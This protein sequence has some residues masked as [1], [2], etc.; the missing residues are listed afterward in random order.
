M[1]GHRNL[2]SEG[3]VFDIIYGVV[4]SLNL[5]SDLIM[6]NALKK[7]V[8]TKDKLRLFLIWN[9]GTTCVC[10]VTDIFLSD[11]NSKHMALKKE[12]FKDIDEESARNTLFYASV[13]FST[14][15][16]I[17]KGGVLYA[18][19]QM[20][21]NYEHLVADDA[22]QAPGVRGPLFAAAPPVA[23]RFEPGNQQGIAV[24]T[25]APAVP[26]TPPLPAPYSAAPGWAPMA[27]AYREAPQVPGQPYYVAFQQPCF[28]VQQPQPEM[29]P[30]TDPRIA[31]MPYYTDAASSQ[32][33][34]EPPIMVTQGNAPAHAAIEVNAA[35]PPVCE[36]TAPQAVAP[37][38][39]LPHDAQSEGTSSEDTQVTAP[40]AQGTTAS[41]THVQ[42]PAEQATSSPDMQEKVILDGDTAA[43]ATSSP[44]PTA[45][46]AATQPETVES[47]AS[48][49]ASARGTP[50]SSKRVPNADERDT[51]A[52]SKAAVACVSQELKTAS[53]QPA[54]EAKQQKR[55]FLK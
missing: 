22:F 27:P 44:V 13:M 37:P 20:Y 12:D 43:T 52:E 40:T 38:G 15:I 16:F 55:G 17:V 31:Y 1:G 7:P 24:G 19:Y 26:M 14:V 39:A 8:Q 4:C 42:T 30:R 3:V 48:R 29:H 33:T 18:I 36:P 34:L 41:D 10:Y 23:F 2:K 49:T 35:Q 54:D 11:F 21:T 50:V 25:P 53:D 28:P 6:L 32:I 47:T 5:V 45:S 46:A 9:A 51:Q